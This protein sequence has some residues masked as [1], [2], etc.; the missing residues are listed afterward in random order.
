MENLIILA[1]HA[2][3]ILTTSF[4]DIKENRTSSYPILL[5]F[6]QTD[7]RTFVFNESLESPTINIDSLIKTKRSK[8]Q[9][10]FVCQYK[11]AE[12][13]YIDINPNKNQK[14]GIFLVK[15]RDFI[16]T[17]EIEN[18]GYVAFILR[19]KG[20]GFD[21]TLIIIGRIDQKDKLRREFEKIIEQTKMEASTA[22]IY[23]L[24]NPYVSNNRQDNSNQ[25]INTRKHS[26]RLIPF[27]IF[28]WYFCQN[29]CNNHYECGSK[30]QQ[31]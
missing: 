14:S 12:F 22:S 26:C 23:F 18:N 4:K 25:S 20:S 6:N 13:S 31:H 10:I 2:T 11:K 8:N 29:I 9:A 3:F 28:K 19:K 7:I 30:N 24:I 21:Q 27:H 17:E 15:K 1:L 16:C 5:R